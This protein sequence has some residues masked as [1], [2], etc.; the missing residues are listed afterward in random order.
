MALVKKYGP[1][2][3]AQMVE[4]FP[5][6]TAKQLSSRWLLQLNPTISKDEWTHAEDSLL[7][8]LF[9]RHGTA[10]KKIT[11]VMTTRTRNQ[12]KNRYNGNLKRRMDTFEFEHLQ[13]P[14][15]KHKSDATQNLGSQKVQEK[16][17]AKNLSL[18]E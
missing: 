13:S 16:V 2:C 9:L 15:Q 10:W 4:N 11:E 7:V 8:R 18:G 14:S 17:L 6:R 3:W 12:V 1:K 5:G